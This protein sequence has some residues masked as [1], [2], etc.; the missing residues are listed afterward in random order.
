[1]NTQELAQRIAESKTSDVSPT[2]N[3]NY[4]APTTH[5][6]ERQV[7]ITSPKPPFP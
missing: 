2:H 6:E 5:Q 7:T 4:K 1:M 3:G